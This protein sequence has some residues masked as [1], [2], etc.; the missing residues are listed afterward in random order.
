MSIEILMPKHGLNMSEGH[1]VEINKNIGDSVA[2]GDVLFIFETSKAIIEFESKHSGVVTEILVEEGDDVPI[3]ELVML[4][5]DA[6]EKTSAPE[7]KSV[8]STE[9]ETAQSATLSQVDLADMVLA[10][11]WVKYNAKQKGI[12][13][14]QIQGTGPGG[15]VKSIDLE[16]YSEEMLSESQR[17]VFY[18]AQGESEIALSRIKKLTGDHLAATFRDVPHIYFSAAVNMSRVR[19]IREQMKAT[20]GGKVSYTDVILSAVIKALTVI[21][22]VN[23]HFREG[24]YFQQEEVNIGFAV[25]TGNGLVVPVLRQVQR[26]SFNE[27]TRQRKNLVAKALEGKLFPEEME[28]GTFTVTNLGGFGIDSFDP[29]VNAPEVAILAVGSL[30]DEVLVEDGAI[31]I[32]PVV[33]LRLACD[34]RALDGADCARYLSTVKQYLE[35]ADYLW[36]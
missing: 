29:I 30:K 22:N 18:D 8:Q 13:L 5:E 16:D 36:E 20:N 26:L 28:M 1:I 21:P 27:M 12:D 3:N 25:A 10:T 2:K 9:V 17:V 32:C 6:G 19:D 34:H 33:Q 4:L 14:R 15:R 31:R 35:N 23:A 24:R 11:P 7:N